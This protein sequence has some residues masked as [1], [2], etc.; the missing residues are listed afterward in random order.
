M[1]VTLVTTPVNSSPTRSRLSQCPHAAGKNAPVCWDCSE[2]GHVGSDGSKSP[3]SPAWVRMNRKMKKGFAFFDDHSSMRSSTV[4]SESTLEWH[5][6]EPGIE[7]DKSPDS[8][9]AQPGL[10]VHTGPTTVTSEERERVTQDK[11]ASTGKLEDGL[12]Q[13]IVVVKRDKLCGLRRKRFWLVLILATSLIVITALGVALG[14]TQ[15]GRSKET[16]G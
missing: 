7:V 13:K 4:R 3:V 6:P 8:R 10:E 1:V 15:R 12:S 2:E 11:A 14:I 16:S 9:K 5:P